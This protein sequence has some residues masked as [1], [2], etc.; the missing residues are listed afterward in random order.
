MPIMLNP[1][2]FVLVL[3][4]IVLISLLIERSLPV[5]VVRVRR[6]RKR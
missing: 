6:N 2:G 4:V 3:G 1:T 5:E